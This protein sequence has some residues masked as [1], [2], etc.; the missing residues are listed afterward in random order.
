MSDRAEAQ[1]FA[2][3][4]R[5]LLSDKID[6]GDRLGDR[7]LDL[8]PRVHLEKVEGIAFIVDEELDRTGAAI[9]QAGRE[10]HRRLVQRAQRRR[11]TRRRRFLDELLVAPL[12]GAV[13]LAQVN[14]LSV[15]VAEDLHFDMAAARD[16]PLQVDAG[17]AERGARLGRREFNR[18]RQILQPVDELHAA[19]AAAAHRF[20]E[21]RRAI[22]RARSAPLRAN[23]RRRPAR[24]GRRPPRL[25]RAR[26]LSPTASI[27]AAVGPMN[28]MLLH[29]TRGRARS[30]RKP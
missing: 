29:R 5:D 10:A 11:Q 16:E 15:A 27:C 9:G 25:R 22:S 30:E 18:R 19:S 17:V 21:Q 23:S 20:D 7:M 8:D 26:S 12:Y 2:A 13:A 6:A 1:S 3:R 24:P 14:D 28:T 4:D